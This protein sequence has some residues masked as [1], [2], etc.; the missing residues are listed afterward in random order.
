M[1][2][3]KRFLDDQ[4]GSPDGVIGTLGAYKIAHP[5]RDTVRKWFERGGI[6]ALWLPMLLCVLEIEN[7]QPVRLANYLGR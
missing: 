3:H 4:F 7:G 2:D 6:P 5:S 1:F